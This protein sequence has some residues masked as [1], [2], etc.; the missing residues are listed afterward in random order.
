MKRLVLIFLLTLSVVA[1]FA[2]TEGFP[3]PEIPGVLATPSERGAYLLEHYWD[4]YDFSDTTLIDRQEIAEQGFANFID[5]LPRFDSIAANKGIMTFGEKAFGGKAHRKVAEG[6]ETMTEHYLA[7]PNSPMRNE[8]LYISFLE[9]QIAAMENVGDNASRPKARLAAATKNRPGTIAAD[10]AFTT[11]EGQRSSL[12]KTEADNLLL[13]FYDPAC[14]HCSEILTTLRNNNN[15]REKVA[16]GKLRVL[17][18]YTEGN[19][20]LWR[21]TCGNMSEEWTVAIDE[22]RIVDNNIYDI[23]AMPIFYLLDKDKK[24]VMKDPALGELLTWIR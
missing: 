12:H 11:R 4:N 21:D 19:R 2:Q 1:T 22:S 6:F 17:A 24:V 8:E 5:L 16:S 9:A 10:F 15:F 20:Q 13:I 14:E 7:D 23:P 3:Y 18:V